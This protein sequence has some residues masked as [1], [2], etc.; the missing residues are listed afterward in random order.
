MFIHCF[1][2]I[3]SD[4]GLPIS[5]WNLE[6][7]AGGVV[8]V[9]GRLIVLS[10]VRVRLYDRDHDHA[11]YRVMRK[12]TMSQVEGG[13][14]TNFGIHDCLLVCNDCHFTIAVRGSYDLQLHGM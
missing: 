1:V 3:Y 10:V 13:Q 6:V 8:H 7:I 12:D 11:S 2:D 14:R 4:C 5:V 9:F